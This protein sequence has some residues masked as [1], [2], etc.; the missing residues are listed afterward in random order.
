[1]STKKTL[2]TIG[3]GPLTRLD[4]DQVMDILRLLQQKIL[5][6][7]ALNGGFDTLLVKID[8]LE[9]SQVGTGKKVD[10]IHEAIYHPDEGLFARVKV[11][12]TIK[13]KVESVDD[14]GRDV[15]LLRQ[16]IGSEEKA[17]EQITLVQ[18]HSN[19][20]RELLAFKAK[21]Y[22]VVKWGLV[23]LGGSGATLVAK[24]IYYFVTGH[25]TVH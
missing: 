7:A 24:L 13:E 20:L 11:I 14:L 18:E 16:R 15:L 25:I 17:A 19:Q 3:V 4:H 23:T 21:V 5:N 10:S 8:K 9:E 12:E 6:S 22:S 1:M 2:P